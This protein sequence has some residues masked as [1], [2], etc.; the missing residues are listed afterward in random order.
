MKRPL[1]CLALAACAAAAEDHFYRITTRTV[2]QG[3]SYQ[4]TVRSELD[5]IALTG[6][7]QLDK[8]I[9]F[10]VTYAWHDEKQVWMT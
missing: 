3:S 6:A 9:H 2:Q 1:L 10:P 8:I 5:P 4:Y 7:M